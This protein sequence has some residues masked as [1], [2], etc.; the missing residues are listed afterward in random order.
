[1]AYDDR[2]QLCL[3]SANILI[4][5]VDGLSVRSVA[6]LLNSS[7][8]RFYYQTRFSDL[9]VLKGNLQALPFPLL[10]AQQDQALSHLAQE[11]SAVA[12]PDVHDR[13]DRLVYSIFG[14]GHEMQQYI[15]HKL[16]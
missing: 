2:Q 13:L 3:N 16:T 6:A 10:T 11:A 14:F 7:L 9:K 8:Y 4:P 12:A 15:A 5:Q 1:V